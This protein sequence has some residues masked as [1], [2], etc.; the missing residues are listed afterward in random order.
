MGKS[1][2]FD[3]DFRVGFVVRKCFIKNRTNHQVEPKRMP[4]SKLENYEDL[5][6]ALVGRYLSVDSL[7][8]ACST[9][10]VAVN[11]RLSFL[12]K[13]RLVE[14]KRCHSKTLYALTKRGLTVQRTLAIA[15]RLERLKTTVKAIDDTFVTVSRSP[16]QGEPKK[17]R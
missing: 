11:E 7:A 4:K 2:R 17:Q 12:I 3:M 14:E 6:A 16:D 8:F 1:W 13:N 15:K 9:D 5:I 10:C